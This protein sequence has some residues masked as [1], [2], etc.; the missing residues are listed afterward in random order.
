[1]IVPLNTHEEVNKLW[2]SFETF[3][4]TIQGLDAAAPVLR[5]LL[6]EAGR[7]L[8]E[9]KAVITGLEQAIAP[10]PPPDETRGADSHDEEQT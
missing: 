7:A 2:H 9:M 10:T 1:M 6:G 4:D 5:P 3:R 8:L